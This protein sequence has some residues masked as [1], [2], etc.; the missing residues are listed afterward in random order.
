MDRISSANAFDGAISNLLSRQE[1]LS[2]TQIQLTSGKRVVH[3]SDDP[4]AAARAERARALIARTDASKRAVDASRSAMTLT[5]SALGDA[6]NLLQSARELVVAAG[7]AS[8]SDAERAAVAK[9]IQS[10]RDQLLSVANRPDGAGGYV[11]SG[12][13]S[14]AAPF[15]DTTAGVQFTGVGGSVHVATDEPLPLTLDG[16]SIWLH[17]NTGNGVFETKNMNSGSAWIDAG[18]VVQPSQLTNSTYSVQFNVS[19]GSTTYAILK[20]G[21][22]TPVTAAAY[23]SGQSITVDGLSFAISGAPASGDKFQ[24][25]PSQPDLSVFAALDTITKALLTKNQ[26]GPQVTQAVQTG[27]RDIDQAASQLQSARSDAGQTLSRLDGVQGRLDASALWGE[28][29]RSNAEDLDMVKALASF[30]NQQTGYQ[31]ALQ[32]YA[33]VQKMSLMQYLNV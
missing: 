12:Q 17:G 19:A 31:A 14:G 6:T 1:D 2:N 3:A 22:P 20:D 8:Y 32:S 33:S 25:A 18:H 26:S 10:V 28:T 29:T 15:S 9:Q 16:G 27:L 21:N 13:G 11:F 7:N 4:T 30:Q 23:T 5:E 24:I